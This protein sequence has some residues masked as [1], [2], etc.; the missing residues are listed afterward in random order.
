MVLTCGPLL[1]F[2]LVVTV[3]RGGGENSLQLAL[4][5]SSLLTGCLLCLLR[6]EHQ[7]PWDIRT[8]GDNH[9]SGMNQLLAWLQLTT[10]GCFLHCHARSFC[11]QAKFTFMDSARGLP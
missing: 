7:G 1:V 6:R 11:Y 9:H 4:P 10:Q 5:G 8:L 3:L 2:H